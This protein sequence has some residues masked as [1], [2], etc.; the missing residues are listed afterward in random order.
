M[1]AERGRERS[2]LDFA[3]SPYMKPVTFDDLERYA[4]LGVEHVIL[5]AGGD[6]TDQTLATI[7]TLVHTMLEPARRL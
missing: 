1:L 4:E 2:E 6:S 5:V 7:D 3:V